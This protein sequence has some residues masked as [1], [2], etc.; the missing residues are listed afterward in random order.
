VSGGDV[1]WSGGYSVG[2]CCGSRGELMVKPPNL[3][4]VSVLWALRLIRVGLGYAVIPDSSQRDRLSPRL[5][6]RLLSCDWLR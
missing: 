4:V 1:V 3:G 2:H 6:H 5:H